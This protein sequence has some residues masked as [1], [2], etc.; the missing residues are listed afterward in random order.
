MVATCISLVDPLPFQ[1][2]HFCSLVAVY[3]LSKHTGT[4]QAFTTHPRVPPECS[5]N[6][7]TR[8]A[9]SA[10]VPAASQPVGT[11]ASNSSVLFT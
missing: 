3:N 2:G 9:A 8:G 4:V 1:T 11:A 6:Q 10:G 5:T 7:Q